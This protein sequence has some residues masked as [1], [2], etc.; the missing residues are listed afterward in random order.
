MNS[1]TLL[2]A[3]VVINGRPFIMVPLLCLFGL[4]PWW[5]EGITTHD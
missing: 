3:D 5:Q 4:L 2:T 1:I